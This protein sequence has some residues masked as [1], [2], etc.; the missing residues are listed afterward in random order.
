MMWMWSNVLLSQAILVS[1][2]ASLEVFQRNQSAV[3][4]VQQR[5]RT[6]CLAL[7]PKD[8]EKGIRLEV[9]ELESRRISGLVQSNNTSKYSVRCQSSRP[10]GE[11]VPLAWIYLK[12][13]VNG[14]IR[15]WRHSCTLHLLIFI[16]VEKAIIPPSWCPISDSKRTGDMS[17]R[18]IGNIVPLLW[19][20]ETL[21]SLL[22]WKYPWEVILDA[23][24]PDA[25]VT[26]A[27]PSCRRRPASPL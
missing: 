20:E 17:L 26:S 27:G 12:G 14:C 2:S 7:R 13:L 23:F 8:G 4:S 22:V 24:W 5:R 18:Q 19:A 1:I 15:T 3:V 6:A 21:K 25:P 9:F 16:L 10:L 11:F